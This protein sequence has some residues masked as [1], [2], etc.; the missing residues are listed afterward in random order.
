MK[1]LKNQK[2]RISRLAFVMVFAGSLM[3]CGSAMAERVTLTGIANAIGKGAIDKRDPSKANATL[4]VDQK[5]LYH[6][7]GWAGIIC[8]TK[9]DGKKVEITGE[10]GDDHG[11][12]TITAKSIDVKIIVVEDKTS[13]K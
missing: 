12:K 10:V 11:K 3:W 1:V 13:A 6:V 7:Y 5:D 9:A 4:K 2:F 8:A